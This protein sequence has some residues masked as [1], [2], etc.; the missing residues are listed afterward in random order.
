[1]VALKDDLDKGVS[2]KRLH[3]EHFSVMLRYGKAVKEYRRATI[4]PRSTKT[5]VILLVGPSGVGKSRFATSLCSFLG[6]TYKLPQ[7]KGSGTYWDDYDGQPV[8]FIDEFDGNF[9]RPTVFNDLCDR[10][11]HVVPVHGSAGHQFVSRYLVICSNY[12]PKYWWKKRSPGQLRQTTRRIDVFIPLL[13]PSKPLTAPS[14]R[15]NGVPASFSDF[16]SH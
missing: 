3:E 11:E 14:F 8:T 16:F 9:M 4:P 6:P 13:T 7:P 2:L 1:M 12:L 5:V 15:F 10:Y